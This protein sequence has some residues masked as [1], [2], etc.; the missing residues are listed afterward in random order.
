MMKT[1]YKISL[2][3]VACAC[4][5][6]TGTRATAITLN[7]GLSDPYA[8][9]VV[10][11]NPQQGAGGQAATDQGVAGT[12]VDMYNGTITV[13]PYVVPSGFNNVDSTYTLSGNNFGAPP[14]TAPSLSGNVIASGVGSGAGNVQTV[15][16]G[17]VDYA[18]IT[19]GASG[20]AAGYGYL[21]ARYDGQNSGTEVWDISG[22]ANVTLYFPEYAQPSGTDLIT[23]KYQIT[24]WTL[25]NPNTPSVPD[26]GSTALLLGAAL[27][28]LGLVHRKFRSA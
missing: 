10:V 15:N 28:L 26:G 3:V 2:A 20:L 27:S 25:F 8:L 9:G 21:V 19:L 5:T 1:N 14:L 16:I 18:E 6:L 22:L 23:G 11:Y 13:N 12:F 24:S 7:V 4:L 17:G